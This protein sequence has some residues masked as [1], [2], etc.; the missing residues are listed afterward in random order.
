MLEIQYM[1]VKSSE[2]RLVDFVASSL[3]ALIM[4]SLFSSHGAET[5]LPDR[6]RS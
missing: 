1:L 6:G 2:S 4:F 5:G 3:T